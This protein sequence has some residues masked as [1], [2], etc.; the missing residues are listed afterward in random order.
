MQLGLILF[1]LALPLLELAVV[2]NVGQHIGVIYTI[3]LLIAMGL[4]GGALL[5][6]Q[7]LAALT[8]SIEAART[9]RPPIGPM[10][11]SMFLMLA[12]VLFI[13]PGFITDALGLLL[14]VPPL[15]H[16]VARWIFSRMMVSGTFTTTTTGPGE[17]D[18]GSQ[19]HW[20]SG[21]PHADA[22]AAPRQPGRRPDGQPHRD[23]DGGVVIE[24]EWER[25]DEPAKRPEDRST[26]H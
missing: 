8:R 6:L 3:L 7:G 14:L 24:G 2:I 22:S 10:I 15:R 12:G 19:Q 26:R 5:R 16:A 4:A 9:G 25:V 23:R 20:P 11:D 17:T 1:C 18:A 21:D 13:I